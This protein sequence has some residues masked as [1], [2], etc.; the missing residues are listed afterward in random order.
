MHRCRQNVIKRIRALVGRETERGRERGEG[1]RR[2]PSQV[3]CRHARLTRHV[4]LTTRYG[5]ASRPRDLIRE[6]RL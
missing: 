2:A 4:C 3:K 5:Y 1:G 6:Y